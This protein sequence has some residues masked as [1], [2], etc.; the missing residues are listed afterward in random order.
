MN[1][2]VSHFDKS[3]R[4][5]RRGFTLVELLV[6]IAI[7]AVL[8]AL[9][10]VVIKGVKLKT[11]KVV[12]TNLFRNVSLAMEEYE[13]DY[14]RPPLPAVKDDWDT[15]LGD[16][17]GLYSTSALVSV[18]SGGMEGEWAEND[19]NFY[20]LERLNS[21]G[22]VYLELSKE[23]SAK[24]GGLASDGKLYDP[25][26]QEIMIAINSRVRYED[27]NNGY[28]DEILHTWG[29]AEWAESKPGHQ[30]YVIWSYGK[31]K[32]KGAG[33]DAN[34]RRSDDVKSF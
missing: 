7:V 3:S 22:Q 28:R 25:W 16:P 31:D 24:E 8:S 10:L 21:N 11:Q 27:A 13:V 9:T 6:V 15:I 1:T 26:G 33:D 34:F 17:G 30:S 12:C 32:V 23:F 5:C 2:S 19:G 18:L 29:L 20:D 14:N 4:L